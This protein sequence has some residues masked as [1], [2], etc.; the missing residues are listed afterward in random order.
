M[1][2]REREKIK[3]QIGRGRKGREEKRDGEGGR[4]DVFVCETEII[5]CMLHIQTITS[6]NFWSQ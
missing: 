1:R 6:L 2:R 5:Q 3:E 4:T